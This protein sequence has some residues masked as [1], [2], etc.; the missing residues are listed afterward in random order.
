MGS[1]RRAIVR[2]APTCT[3]WVGSEKRDG[4]AFW[5]VVRL[6]HRIVWVGWTHPNQT[7]RRACLRIGAWMLRT[8]G[9]SRQELE[10]IR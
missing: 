8:F 9:I 3:L 10:E 2:A 7:V 5:P 6:Q 1:I 4:L